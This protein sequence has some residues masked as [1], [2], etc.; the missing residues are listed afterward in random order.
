MFCLHVYNFSR[1]KYL[2][3]LALIVPLAACLGGGDGGPSG[4]SDSGHTLDLAW[5]APSG[6]EDS[7][8]LSLSEIAGFRIYYGTESGSYEN[9]HDIDD[10]TAVNAQID[11]SMGTYYIV[12]TTIDTDGRESSY[13]PEVKVTI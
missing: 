5:V 3:I 1:L 4:A 12:M 11:V 10:S 8:G 7:S 6:R 9:R 2:L 13:S